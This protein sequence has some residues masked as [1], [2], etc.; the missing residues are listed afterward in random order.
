MPA[1]SPAAE[2]RVQH[3][4]IAARYLFTN[5][6]PLPFVIVGLGLMLAAW[7]EPAPLIAWGVAST[8]TWMATISVIRAFLSDA[9]KGARIARWTIAVC[10]T[11]FVSATVFASVAP[12]FWVE[13]ERLNNVLLYVLVAASLASAGAQSAPSTPVVIANLTPY[14]LV[15]LHLSLANET[16]PMNVGLA[17]LQLCYI[18]LVAL[19]ART[20]WQLA[21]DMLRL[22]LEKR[23]LIDKLQHALVE[24]TKAKQKAEAASSAKSEFLANMS[25]ELRTPLNA[26]LGFSEIIRDRMLGEAAVGRYSEYGGH[27]HFSGRHL[28]G[29]IGDIL[30]L[31]KIEAGKRELDERDVDLMVIARDALHFVEPQAQR[32]SLDLAL[33]GPA[34]AVVRADER[35]MRQIIANLLSNAVKFTPNAGVVTLRVTSDPSTGVSIVV[36]DTGVGIRPEDMSKI[37]ESFGQARHDVATTDEQGTGLGLPIVKG[38]VGLHGGTLKIDSAPGKGTSVTVTLPPAR[39]V[40]VLETVS[41]A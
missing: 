23:E 28:L 6:L 41:A 17:F 29:L 19:Y 24:A 13:G 22:R 37:M 5:L 15:F 25:H 33:D 26:I 40:G 34:R 11:L 4:E 36:T 9:D 12:L 39:M 20:V 21:D 18:V 35:A 8:L 3:L 2:L 31:S 27:I 38:L 30:D 14:G 7:H 16:F 1:A 32:K 10:A